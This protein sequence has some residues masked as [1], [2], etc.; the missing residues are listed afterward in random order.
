[1][2]TARMPCW[3][4]CQHLGDFRMKAATHILSHAPLNYKLLIARVRGAE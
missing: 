4:K 2:L 3:M 1:L